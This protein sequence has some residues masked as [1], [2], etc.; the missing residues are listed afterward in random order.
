[1]PSAYRSTAT[2]TCMCSYRQILSDGLRDKSIESSG[3]LGSA[4]P[5]WSTTSTWV[6][7]ASTRGLFDS[8]GETQIIYLRSAQSRYIN[9]AD[10]V[11]LSFYQVL[12]KVTDDQTF[13]FPGHS[14]STPA[15]GRLGEWFLCRFI[16]CL[17]NLAG[18]ATVMKFVYHYWYK[19]YNINIL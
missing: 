2:H 10:E 19:Y 17:L 4:R 1:M 3:A 13:P 12:L 14:Q 18:T 7:Q 8:S 9:T 11:N 16:F 5:L 6:V 15:K